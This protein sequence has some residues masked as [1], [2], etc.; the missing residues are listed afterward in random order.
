MFFH[1][2]IN[3]ALLNFESRTLENK[4]SL[5][6]IALLL[7]IIVESYQDLLVGRFIYRGS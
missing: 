5:K 3:Y 1:L 4:C 2:L 6:N 7:G